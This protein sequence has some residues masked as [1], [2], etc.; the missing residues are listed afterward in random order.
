MAAAAAFAVDYSEY[1]HQTE[2]INFDNTYSLRPLRLKI[3]HDRLYMLNDSFGLAIQDISVLPEGTVTPEFLN[4]DLVVSFDIQDDLLCVCG[5][6]EQSFYDISGSGSPVLLATLNLPG[7][8][9]EVTF[10][11]NHVYFSAEVEDTRT[12]HV[13]NV[14][15]PSNPTLIRSVDGAFGHRFI[16]EGNYLFG[17][18]RGIVALDITSEDHPVVAGFWPA[19]DLGYYPVDVA[20]RQGYV[21]MPSANEDLLVLDVSD[22]SAMSLVLAW[23]NGDFADGESVEVVGETLLLG[24]DYYSTMSFDISTPGEPV[25]TGEAGTPRAFDMEVQGELLFMATNY[26]QVPVYTLGNGAF[27]NEYR[28]VS[29]GE[30]VVQVAGLPSGHHAVLGTP[31]RLLVIDHEDWTAPSTLVEIVLPGELM[32][33]G[34]VGNLVMATMEGMGLWVW[35]LQSPGYPVG[36]GAHP[37]IADGQ[38]VSVFEDLVHVSGEGQLWILD[39]S[40][41]GIPEVLGQVSLGLDNSYGPYH[42]GLVGDD[43]RVCVTGHAEL[44]VIDTSDP[45]H[46]IAGPVV[47]NDWFAWNVDLAL[48]GDLLYRTYFHYTPV[49]DLSQTGAPE[50]GLIYPTGG[51]AVWDDEFVYVQRDD[52]GV[53]LFE[54]LGPLQWSQIGQFDSS[55]LD[56]HCLAIS[57]DHVVAG[58]HDG[59]LVAPKHTPHLSSVEILP[60]S[61][62]ADKVPRPA[63]TGCYPNPFNPQ[64]QIRFSLPGPQWVSLEIHDVAGRLVRLLAQGEFAEGAH[65]L[66]WDGEDNQGRH[67]P[68]GVYLANLK[69]RGANSSQRM[70]LVR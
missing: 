67:L 37:A 6:E 33:M 50:V 34:V 47:N 41:S 62:S 3:A 68:S 59:Y 12:L 27:M 19:L 16:G 2:T 30:G 56:G 25:F 24:T 31:S 58:T 26:E 40:G 65:T 14:Q 70:T 64:V 36:L 55:W 4:S 42:A 15:D 60:A 49:F 18:N 54:E 21:Y 53:L 32:E 23:D 8:A 17:I 48:R 69:T 5:L 11:G 51:T 46:P 43:H 28:K 39:G 61:D 63:I 35:D 52:G 57:D 13:V 10:N 44:Q 7:W 20:C 22:P 38:Q 66:E 45:Y 1:I 9:R 29:L